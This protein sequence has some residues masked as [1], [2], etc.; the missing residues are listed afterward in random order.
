[1]IPANDN[2]QRPAWFDKLLLQ[3]DPLLRKLSRKYAITLDAEDI[4][5]ETFA[6]AL[7]KWYWYDDGPEGGFAPWLEF[8][9]LKV[10]SRLARNDRTQTM[11]SPHPI[12]SPANQEHYTDIPRT[13][14]N[15]TRYEAEV[16]TMKAVGYSGA[17]IGGAFGK[18]RASVYC[19]VRDARAF[20]RAANDNEK[21]NAAA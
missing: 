16:L 7:S 15:V 21:K 10:V 2:Q 14:N 8:Q 17:E 1:M 3:Y 11:L 6:H 12:V 5:Q 13:L 19:T 20:L 4:Y 18:T 9:V